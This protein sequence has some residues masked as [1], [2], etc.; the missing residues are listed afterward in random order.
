MW[1]SESWKYDSVKSS[2]II[3]DDASSRWRL[4]IREGGEWSLPRPTRILQ[5]QE[6]PFE[7][8]GF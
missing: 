2:V 8:A 1:K 3:S 6:A 7:E 4:L 5:N